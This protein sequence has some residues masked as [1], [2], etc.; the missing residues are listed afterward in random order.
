[1]EEVKFLID[2]VEDP[3][4]KGMVHAAAG[5]ALDVVVGVAADS[6]QRMMATTACLICAAA[7]SSFASMRRSTCASDGRRFPDGSWALQCCRGS[8]SRVVTDD[9]REENHSHVTRPHH[10]GR[11][12]GPGGAERGRD[13]IGRRKRRD[14]T[15]GLRG[16]KCNLSYITA[17]GPPML[18]SAAGNTVR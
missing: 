11:R 8:C 17:R 7:A 1:V 18:C 9:D 10:G 16:I 2:R 4:A 13:P 14:P 6:F 5:K 12:K 3:A 15:D